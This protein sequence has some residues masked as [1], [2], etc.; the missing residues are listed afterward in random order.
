[1]LELN[2]RI[3]NAC[4]NVQNKH[5]KKHGVTEAKNLSKIKEGNEENALFYK[6]VTYRFRV[7]IVV[8]LVDEA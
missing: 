5:Q 2:Y 6:K 1:M 8:Q 7:L 3:P 4:E